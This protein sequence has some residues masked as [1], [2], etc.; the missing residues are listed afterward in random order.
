MCQ[1]LSWVF[2]LQR[3]TKLALKGLPAQEKERERKEGMRRTEKAGH[4]EGSGCTQLERRSES[5]P[6]PH[7]GQA[8]AISG[9]F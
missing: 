2:R 6:H 7:P 5:M 1:A 8:K 3:R 4:M 9:M